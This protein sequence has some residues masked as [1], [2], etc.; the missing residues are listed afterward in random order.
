MTPHLNSITQTYREPGCHGRLMEWTID[1]GQSL[2][3][4]QLARAE[5]NSKNGDLHLVLGSSLTVSPA[6][7]MPKYT[8]KNGKLL[9][10][11][12]FS[13]SFLLGGKLVICNLQKTPLYGLADINIHAPCDYVMSEVLRRLGI[14]SEEWEL[15]RKIV[16]GVRYRI[17]LL[18]E[19]DA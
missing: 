19:P 2:P 7:N 15:R 18:G 14:K 11:L 1:F 17:G 3:V 5:A 10:N 8:K 9:I 16:V 4:D 13:L 6:C 12:L